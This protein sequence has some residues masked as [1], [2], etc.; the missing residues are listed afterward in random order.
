MHTLGTLVMPNMGENGTY[1]AD[2][3]VNGDCIVNI[4]DLVLVA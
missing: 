4:V 1:A 2:F 3:D